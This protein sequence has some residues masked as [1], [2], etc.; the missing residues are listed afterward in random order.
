MLGFSG[1]KDSL[2]ALDI[3]KKNSKKK[4]ITFTYDWSILSKIA[5]DT[6]SLRLY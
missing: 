2:M 3:L 4:I 5:R 1:G 6:I